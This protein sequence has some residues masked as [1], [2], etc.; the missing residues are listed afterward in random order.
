[1]DKLIFLDTE[2]TGNDF[3]IDR[4]FEIAY[5]FN[6]ETHAEYFKPPVPISVKSSSITH[7]TNEMVSDK[8]LFESSQMK[9]NLEKILPDN[10]LV[11][12]SASF[13]IGV[14]EKEGLEVPQ[15]IC[16]LKVARYLDSESEIPEYGLQYLRYYHSLNVEDA[17]A[18]DARS[19]IKVLEALFNFLYEK[20]KASGKSEDE[21]I[22]EMIR[23]SREPVLFKVFGFG[24]HRGK[25]LEEVV[26]YDR[27]YLEWMLD[28][29]LQSNEIQEDWI[30]TLKYYLQI[31]D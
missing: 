8:P 26:A 25:K 15:Y 17:R 19:D 30:F 2:T 13:D 28:Q 11:A 6:G 7:V 9:K 14:L 27:K 12:H 3:L 16:T 31:K 24:K 1:M 5:K 22:Y 10:I 23:I 29:K 18:H 20:M 21:I 4:L